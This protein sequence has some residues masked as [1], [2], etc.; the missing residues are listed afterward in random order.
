MTSWH[1]R[2]RGL[3]F[4]TAAITLVGC[5]YFGKPTGQDKV[6]AQT[7][8]QE[9]ANYQSWQTPDWVEGY[10]ES[11]HPLPAYVKYYVN[12]AGMSDI[13][14]PPNGSIFVKEQFDEDKKIIGL[15]VMKKVDGYDPEN[16][17]WYWAIADTEA[18]ITNAGKLNS[19]WTSSCISCHKKGDGGDDLLFVND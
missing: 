1:T 8:E 11:V 5:T 13:D 10:T 17:D 12:A 16:K 6:E 19:S 4:A 9:I 3:V 15:T 14:N 2:I 18:R 7:L